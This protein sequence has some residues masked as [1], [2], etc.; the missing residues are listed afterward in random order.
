MSPPHSACLN[1]S[2][3][4]PYSDVFVVW[5]F[6]LAAGAAPEHDS[7]DEDCSGYREY[8]GFK[9]A[10][11]SARLHCAYVR[12]ALKRIHADKMKKSLRAKF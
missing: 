9:S 12:R 11:A 10:A 2:L 1:M 7:E 8:A 6:S 3:T 4:G 5:C